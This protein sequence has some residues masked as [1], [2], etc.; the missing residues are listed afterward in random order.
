MSIKAN[1]FS[2]YFNSGVNP[3]HIL[4]AIDAFPDNEQVYLDSKYM[5]DALQKKM[6]SDTSM[7]NTD[8]IANTSNDPI[9][10]IGQS[11]LLDGMNTD[12]STVV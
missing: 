4:Q 3:R 8:G 5:F 10:Q 2:T 9:N 6:V 11:P 12:R 1:T 7:G